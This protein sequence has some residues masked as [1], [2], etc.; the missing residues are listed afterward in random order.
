MSKVHKEPQEDRSPSVQLLHGI[1]AGRDENAYEV[2]ERSFP[3]AQIKLVHNIRHEE[4]EVVD[5]AFGQ[6]Q[7]KRALVRYVSVR[8]A[9]PGLIR[10]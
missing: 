10:T 9:L 2:C 8:S 4:F 7:R 6:T 5:R 1:S 3:D